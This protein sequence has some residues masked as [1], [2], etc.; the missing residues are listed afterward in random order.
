MKRK[1]TRHLLALVVTLTAGIII[2]NREQDTNAEE[3]SP[4]QK[5]TTSTEADSALAEAF[6][7]EPSMKRRS[8]PLKGEAIFHFID[9]NGKDVSGMSVHLKVSSSEPN[10]K[11]K[12][13]TRVSNNNGES[14]FYE[15]QPGTYTWNVAPHQTIL[16]KEKGSLTIQAG[17]TTTETILVGTGTFVTGRLPLLNRAEKRPHLRLYKTLQGES[18]EE[19]P[20]GVYADYNG[21]FIIPATPGLGHVTAFWIEPDNTHYITATTL[22]IQEGR[23]DVGTLPLSP[24]HIEL[25]LAFEVNGKEYAREEVFETGAFFAVLAI[26]SFNY[27]FYSEMVRL[28]LDEDPHILGLWDGEWSAA[29]LPRPKFPKTKNGFELRVQ[30]PEVRF[31]TP[32]EE[33]VQLTYQVSRPVK[34]TLEVAWPKDPFK[35]ELYIRP[36][37]STKPNQI[38]IFGMKSDEILTLT[39]DEG[40]YD[41]LFIPHYAAGEET[42][43]SSIGEINVSSNEKIRI[44]AAPGVTFTGRTPH[45]HVKAS[46]KGW[47]GI[48]PFITEVDKNGQ[49]E[50]SGIPLNEVL[51]VEEREVF[52]GNAQ[53][54]RFSL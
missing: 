50:I 28:S 48:F 41:Y 24:N 22:E 19:I 20:G 38:S 13:E 18:S 7:D 36:K 5:T 3:L 23:N 1:R 21:S 17:M 44:T 25:S 35:G 15:L 49:W 34:A 53:N 4:A 16:S 43:A 40:E 9:A 45:E 12:I 30:E 46:L 32:Q 6:E 52:T 27:S 14:Q 51:Y 42:N 54:A 33:R 10:T 2:L 39:I 29:L 37:G 31:F 47:E 8:Q 26:N 11:K